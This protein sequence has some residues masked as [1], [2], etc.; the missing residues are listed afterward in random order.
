MAAAAVPAAPEKYPVIAAGAGL[1]RSASGYEFARDYPASV[2]ATLRAPRAPGARMRTWAHNCLSCD[3]I[4]HS[5]VWEPAITA[6]LLAGLLADPAPAL[7]D[8]GAQAGYYTVLAASQGV[9]ALAV[10]AF[11]QNAFL[12]RQTAVE[13]DYK[14]VF[15]VEQAAAPPGASG[16]GCIGGRGGDGAANGQMGLSCEYEPRL[17]TLD[18]MLASEFPAWAPRPISVLKMDIESYEVKALAGATGLLADP[19]RKPC[20]MFIEYMFNDADGKPRAYFCN[21]LR[22]QGYTVGTVNGYTGKRF[23]AEGANCP[24]ADYLAVAEPP[25]RPACAQV[26]AAVNAR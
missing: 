21:F 14:Q 20:V 19:A 22:Q 25:P 16:R 17:A 11:D 7:L 8:V 23:A 13:M 26:V 1:P 12:L 2:L 5:G 9:P 6:L 15:L 24:N 3:Q 18:A 10:E 4:Q